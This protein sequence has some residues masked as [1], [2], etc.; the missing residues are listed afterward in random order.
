MS[1]TITLRHR[2][3]ALVVRDADTIRAIAAGVAAYNRGDGDQQFRVRRSANLAVRFKA[4]EVDTLNAD[5]IDLT[6]VGNPF[7]PA[8]AV[9]A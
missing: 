9:A 8:E 2:E 4:S 6:D 3:G 5:G 1:A 7:A